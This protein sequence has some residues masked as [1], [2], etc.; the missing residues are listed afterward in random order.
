M[1][2]GR[3]SFCDPPLLRPCVFGWLLCLLS[4]VLRPFKA[5]AYFV[6]LIFCQSIRRSVQGDNAPPHVPPWLRLLS[7]LPPSIG[8]N[9]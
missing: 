6:H 4:V 2:A 7:K 9:S 5:A 8:A 3:Q 1:P